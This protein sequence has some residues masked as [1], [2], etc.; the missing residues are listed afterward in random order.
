MWFFGGKKEEF[1]GEQL[2]QQVSNISSQFQQQLDLSWQWIS[3]LHA[4]LQRAH[5]NVHAVHTNTS[6]V[7]RD[8]PQIR[9]EIERAV[10]ESV[11]SVIVSHE[12]NVS[13][14]IDSFERSVHASLSNLS[15]QY[16]HLSPVLARVERLESDIPRIS[17]ALES[18]RSR[19]EQKQESVKQK[20]SLQERIEKRLHHRSKDFLKQSVR[21]LIQKYGR[22]SAL[23]IREMLVDEQ[24][25]CSKSTLY[26]ILDELES[27]FQTHID[28][29]EKVFVVGV[30]GDSGR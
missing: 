1:S 13:R 17:S 18:L 28:G 5:S 20:S 8:I 25:L 29:R 22:L 7:Q 14:R 4:E 15:E 3:F 6:K 16:S 12:Q 26:R 19:L 30:V 10:G 27:E 11:H 24:G 21:S 9:Q 23:Q 2:S